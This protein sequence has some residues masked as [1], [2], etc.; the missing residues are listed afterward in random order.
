[1]LHRST[2]SGIFVSLLTLSLL[3]GML[4]FNPS[5]LVQAHPGS[6]VGAPTSFVPP[7]ATVTPPPPDGPRPLIIP[8]DLDVI[9]DSYI[10]VYKAGIN[11]ALAVADDR[12]DV[13]ALGGRVNF[14]YTSAL[15]GYAA[16]L[17]GPALERA[18]AN[19]LVDYV[20]ADGM[21]TLDEGEWKPVDAT[22][23][24]P[25]WGLDRIDQRSR[26]L[27]N[28]YTYSTTASNVNVYI[29]DTGIN[30][31][32]TEFGGRAY[33]IFDGIG[34]GQNGNDCWGHGT[35]VAGTIGGKKYGVAKNVKLY[36]VRVFACEGT[37]PW[38]V[39]IAGVDYVRSHHS[40][41]SV[42]NMSLGGAGAYAPFETAVQS[43]I[44]AGMTVVVSAGNDNTN[45]CYYSPA[46][47]AE[48]ITVGATNSLD[49]R[50][51]FSNQGDCLDLFAPGQN[52]TSAYIGS[53][54]ALAI[55][56]GTSMAAP[57]VTGVAALYLSRNPNATPAQVAE[58]IVNHATIG[59]VKNIWG[60]SPNRLLYSAFYLY[61]SPEPLLPTGP[62]SDKAPTYLWKKVP[63]ATQYQFQVLKVLSGGGTVQMYAFVVPSSACNADFCFRDTT[64][65]LSYD[66][67][68]WQVRAYKNGKWEPWTDYET[69]MIRTKGG[70]N[71]QFTNNS[72]GWKL[73]DANNGL[74]APPWVLNTASPGNYSSAS[75]SNRYSAIVHN[76]SYSTFTYSVRMRR[77]ANNKQVWVN[78]IW[79]RGEPYSNGSGF[80]GYAHSKFG[81]T[82]LQIGYVDGAG[83][84][85]CMFDVYVAGCFN[86]TWSNL[87]TDSWNTLTVTGNGSFF[88]FFV[89]GTK[90]FEASMPVASSGEAG[91][92]FYGGYTANSEGGE[93]ELGETL[94]V[95]YAWL[96]MSAPPASSSDA[97]TGHYGVVLSEIP[98]GIGVEL[99]FTTTPSPTLTVSPSPSITPSET[100][101]ATSSASET[102]SLTP[103]EEA[104]ATPT[105]TASQT[106]T[107]TPT[108]TTTETP[109]GTAT[110]TP[111]PLPSETPTATQTPSETPTPTPTQT[112]TSF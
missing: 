46:E 8:D 92:S 97:A 30:A 48:A 65:V 26:P 17:P 110:E 15:Q 71:S 7:K 79:F 57:H 52:I 105:E 62:F 29:I 13:E 54:N 94:F 32:H 45:A 4:G 107:E 73:F 72:N 98:V 74:G 82:Y 55:S 40:N 89:N 67:F 35:H 90:V 27:S 31:S 1:M 104:S 28:S 20:I 56:S 83:Q 6:A 87:F 84:F 109:Q 34:D 44:D 78:N 111:I 103:S 93:Y 39:L 60:S 101:T 76:N 91:I 70:F 80:F 12:A 43:L 86:G 38:S 68:K 10:V 41:P 81:G 11:T 23:S 24:N 64:A 96:K 19:P 100:P 53:P 108:S 85:R 88:Q 95:D 47:M 49:Q 9:P 25:T 112:P 51:S 102:P 99:A 16:S 66:T 42:V 14:V 61:P 37:S 36:A 2:F 75:V 21:A 58:A 5:S 3:T 63:G 77:A 33:K 22:Q 18:R 59:K 106:A 50:A 69:F